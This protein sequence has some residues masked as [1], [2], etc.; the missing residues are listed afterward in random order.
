M[1]VHVFPILNP[2]PLTYLFLET[3]I[4]TN[5]KKHS[6]GFQYPPQIH[7]LPESSDVILLGNRVTED[8]IN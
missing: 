5:S 3:N 2:P 7:V 1:G 6:T 4:D 8:V